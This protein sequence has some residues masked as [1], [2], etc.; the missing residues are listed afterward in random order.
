[1]KNS[2]IIAV[3]MSGV[4]LFDKEYQGATWLVG[5]ALVL[6]ILNLVVPYPSIDIE[7]DGSMLKKY[8]KD[9]C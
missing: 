3:V 9:L 6:T 7:E 1:M 4:L 5:A 2:S 8:K